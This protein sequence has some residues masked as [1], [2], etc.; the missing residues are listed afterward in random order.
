MMQFT[1]KRGP[2]V[3]NLRR[4]EIDQIDSLAFAPGEQNEI[5]TIDLHCHARRCL[6]LTDAIQPGKNLLALKVTQHTVTSDQLD[7]M[8]EYADFDLAGIIR[9]VYLFRTPDKHV[10]AAEIAT[11][12]AKEYRDATISGKMAVV[13]ESDTPL[14]DAA[15]SFTLI[16][17]DGKTAA[18]GAKVLPAGIA[19]WQRI[20]VAVDLPVKSP[21]KWDAEHPRLYLLCTEL[22]SGNRV[23]QSLDQK[24]GL[25]TFLDSSDDASLTARRFCGRRRCFT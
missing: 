8:S 16:S 5:A 7:K 17:A 13:N 24:I 25:T 10:A 12:F 21:E 11:V 4:S 15:L 22:T 23:I 14:G 18:N 1:C 9:G 20:D 19:A 2:S 3:F 6:V